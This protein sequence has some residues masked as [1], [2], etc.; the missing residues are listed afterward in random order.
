MS[1]LSVTYIGGPTALLE[2]GGLRLLTDPTFDPAGTEHHLP[3]YIL[4]KTHGP[5]LTGGRARPV[6]A[7]LL[8]HDHHGDNLDAGRPGDPGGTSRACSPRSGGRRAA[9]RHRAV[10]LATVGAT[11]LARAPTAGCCG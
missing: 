6:D 5:A 7:V 1:L 2:V 10:G 3:A 9:G 4:R 8:S 11:G